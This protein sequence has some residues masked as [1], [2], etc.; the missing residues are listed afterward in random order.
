MFLR[1]QNTPPA[2][3]QR[4]VLF[5]KYAGGS[6]VLIAKYTGGVCFCPNKRKTKEDFCQ[7]VG[8]LH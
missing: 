1:G 6:V 3:F 5:G 2:V 8:A 7:G 4:G